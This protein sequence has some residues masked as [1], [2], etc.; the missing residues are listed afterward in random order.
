[1]LDCPL[2][3]VPG[4][5]AVCEGNSCA[6]LGD[7]PDGDMPLGGLPPELLLLGP[8]PLDAAGPVFSEAVMFDG[9]ACCWWCWRWGDCCPGPGM[10]GC[11]GSLF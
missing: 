11:P 10:D 1:M 4:T 9:S 7:N 8:A 3:A 6:K 2:P 5:S